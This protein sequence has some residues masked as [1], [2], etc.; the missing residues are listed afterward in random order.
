MHVY[1]RPSE[2]PMGGEALRDCASS[3]EAFLPSFSSEKN[4]R[5]DYVRDWSGVKEWWV[6]KWNF[7]FS[8]SFMFF[9]ITLFSPPFSGLFCPNRFVMLMHHEPVEENWEEIP[10]YLFD[11]LLLNLKNS[12]C[13][14]F[15][16]ESC[17]PFFHF[18]VY[19]VAV[20]TAFIQPFALSLP[21]LLLMIGN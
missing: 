5:L 2:V 4:F 16:V 6:W 1:G 21:E 15:F 20:C 19:D 11:Q 10:K 13:V 18:G 12:N 7:V 3:I 9:F 8:N 17:G 14:D